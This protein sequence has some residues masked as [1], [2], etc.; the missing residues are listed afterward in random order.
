[1]KRP[2]MLLALTGLVACLSSC[3]FP[4]RIQWVHTGHVIPSGPGII[5]PVYAINGVALQ[6][7]S[8]KL[9]TPFVYDHRGLDDNNFYM[10]QAIRHPS[11]TGT[12]HMG[13]LSPQ[14]AYSPRPPLLPSHPYEIRKATLVR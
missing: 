6:Q 7:Y 5:G 1:M 14:V 4:P 2:L 11:R 3:A 13:P 9:Y 10:A 12:V 8:P